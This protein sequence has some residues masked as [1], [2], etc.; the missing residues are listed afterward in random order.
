MSGKRVFISFDFDNDK[1]LPGNLVAQA[2]EKIAVFV[3]GSLSEGIIR[4][5]LETKGQ[6]YHRE[7][8]S[9]DHHMR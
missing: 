6:E 1:D 4:R 7:R 3:P 9:R 2:N 5:E 8:R